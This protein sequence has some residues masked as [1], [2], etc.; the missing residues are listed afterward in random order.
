MSHIRLAVVCLIA[1]AVSVPFAPLLAASA[2]GIVPASAPHGARVIVTGTGLDA[3]STVVRFA[4]AGGGTATA[5]VIS[6]SPSA[7]EVV[8]PL[9]A[10]S[11]DVH[12]SSEAFDIGTFSFTLLP[13]PPFAKVT[14]LAASDKA[15]DVFKDPSGVA[16]IASTGAVVV[17]DR[18]HHQIKVV[19]PNGQVT[20]LAGS[21]KP[22]LADGVGAQATF[23]E[24]RGIAVD[25]TRKVI[26]I[27]DTGNNV[28]RR[29]TYDG[30]VTTF[31]GSGREEDFKQPVGLAVDAAGNVYIADTGNSRIR[32]ISPEGGVTTVA[33]GGHEGFADGP[34]FQALFKQPEGVALDASGAIFVADT[35][36]NVIRKI[37]N[38]LVSTIAGTGHGGYTDGAGS[39]AEF[40]QPSGISVDD[41]GTVY[42]ADV[43]NNVIRRITSSGV[44]ST[45][46]GTGKSGLVDGD[47]A[48][49]Q[50]NQ[51]A[52]IAFASALYVADT[53]NDALRVI[54]PVLRAAA[55]YPHAGPIAGANQVRILGTGFLPGVTQVS[56]ASTPATA[57]TFI[58]PT[59]L[60]VTAPA[61]SA[62]TVDV[63]VTTPAASDVLASSYT[64]LPPPTIASITPRKGKTAGGEVTTLLGTDFVDPDT[65]VSLAGVASPLV[66][67]LTPST[68]T[69][70]TPVGSSGP[71]DVMVSTP[72]GTATLPLGFT[73][74]APP[75][76]ASFSP[77]S[78]RAGTSVTLAGTNFDSEVS[79]N[80]VTFA[81]MFATI[82]SATP[83]SMLVTVPNGALSGPL[84]L[85][86]AGGTATTASSFTVVSYASITI[87]PAQIQLNIT[88]SKQLSLTGGLP[89][90]SSVDVTP[91]AVWTSLN[92]A[93]AT[94][95]ARG[96]VQAAGAGATTIRATLAGLFATGPVTVT[97]A[98]TPPPDPSTFAT[99]IDPTAVTA[100][101]D[102]TAFLYTGPN[103]IQRNVVPG[104]ITSQR[105]AVIRGK[106]VD[107]NGVGIA[108]ARV[109]VL[110]QPSLGYAVTRQD[111]IYDLAANG[112]ATWTLLMS[113]DG[114]LSARRQVA[115]P[116]QDYVAAPTVALLP[117]D[118]HVTTID[119]TQATAQTARGS[120]VTDADG[121]RQATL[122]FA[123]STTATMVLPDG[124]ARALTSLSVRA[125][126]YTVGAAGPMAMPADLP[127][128]SGYTYCVE[129]SVDEAV[130]AGATTVQ[131]SKPVAFYVENFLGFAVGSPV[132]TGYYDTV[133]GQWRAVA[134]GRVVKIVSITNGL[135]DID[136]DGDGAAD[137]PPALATLGIT[138]AERAQLATTYSAGA[139]LWRTALDHFTTWD[140]NWPV[141]P[142]EDA[143]NPNQPFPGFDATDENTC[144]MAGSIIQCQNQ[145]LGE[146]VPVVGTPFNLHYSSDRVL[147][148]TAARTLNISVSGIT[149]PASLRRIDV[150]VGIAG[151]LTELHFPPLPNQSYK[152]VWDGKDAYGRVL[153]GRQPFSLSIG[154]AYPLVYG[155]PQETQFGFARYGNAL[156]NIP[157]RREAILWQQQSG[158]L[159]A[160][161]AAGLGG[162]TIDVAHLFDRR[163]GVFYYGDGTT[164]SA[165][166]AGLTVKTIVTGIFTGQSYFMQPSVAPDGS[167]YYTDFVNRRILKRTLSGALTVVAGG[168]SQPASVDGVPATSASISSGATTTVAPDGTLYIADFGNNRVRKVDG[169][170]LIRTV[171]GNGSFGFLNDVPALQAKV[172]RPTSIAVGKDG[173]LYIADD[174]H[175]RMVGADGFIHTFAGTGNQ[176]TQQVD[177]DGLLA[178]ELNLSSPQVA[179]GPDGYVYIL[180]NVWI[181]RVGPDGRTYR[182]VGGVNPFTGGPTGG[183]NGDGGPARDAFINAPTSLQ[184][185]PDG[186]LFF[187]A[188]GRVR[189]VTPDGIITSIAGVPTRPDGSV[190]PKWSKSDGN[191]ASATN[192]DLGGFGIALSPTGDLYVADRGFYAGLSTTTG[193]I[194]A[195]QL[196]FGGLSNFTTTYPSP[197]GAEV[198]DFDAAGRHTRTRDAVTNATLYTFTYDANGLIASVKD[199]DDLVTTIERDGAGNASAIVAPGG[200]RTALTIGTDGYLALVTDPVGSTSTFAY[201]AGG[202][203]ATFADPRH[204]THTF[205]FDLDGRLIKDAD[206]ASGST[207][208][209]RTI[210]SEADSVTATDG[211]N[212]S[213]TYAHTTDGVGYNDLVTNE[214][215]LVTTV[216]NTPDGNSV[217]TSP[218]GTT[219]TE[220]LSSDPRFGF[221]APLV[222]SATTTLPSQ[223]TMVIQRSRLVSPAG[224]TDPQNFS[225]F[226]ETTS[227][228]GK[229]WTEQYTSATRTRLQTSPTGRRRI[230][231]L[232][233]S[234]RLLS[235]QTGAL[236]PISFMYDNAGRLAV[237]QQGARI[238][239]LTYD[240]TNALTS[241]TDSLDHTIRFTHD[242]AG[243]LVTGTLADS[244]TITVGYDAS[245]N[246]T[247]V[248]PPARLAHTFQFNTIDQIA[249]YV[250][251]GS[252][253]KTFEYNN[254]HDVASISEPDASKL[255]VGYD[256]QG[257]P[258]SV[259]TR[260]GVMTLA[261]DASSGL[262]TGLTNSSE[263]LSMTYDGRLLTDTS[264]NG[265]VVGT[266]N[267]S[268]DNDFELSGETVCGAGCSTIAFGRDADGL[269][270][271]VGALSLTRDQQNGYVNSATAGGIAEQWSYNEFGE[272]AAFVASYGGTDIFSA[273][274]TRDLIGRITES[275][276][277]AGGT[278]VNTTY[279]Y[280]DTG[281]LKTVVRNGTSTSY[282]YD[283]NNNRL[284]QTSNDVSATG[285]YDGQDRVL[286]YGGATYSFTANGDLLTKSTA[287]GTN[288]YAY[289]ALGSLLEV[290]LA[291]GRTIS[292]TS[293]PAG[294][295]ITVKLNGVITH[296]W[297]Y[298]DNHRIAA[299]LDAAGN[300]VS[301]FVYGVRPNAPEL[302]IRGGDTYRLVTDTRGSIRLVVSINTGTIE[303]RI[304]YD[305]FGRVLFDSNPGF[306][307][308]GF[309]GGIYDPQTGL[310]RFGRRDYDPET[311]RWTSRDPRL[312]RGQDTNLYAYVWND[313]INFI[314]PEGLSGM[315]TVHSNGKN[316][317]SDSPI[318]GHSWISYKPDGGSV[319]TYGTYGNHPGGNDNGLQTNWERDNAGK[320]GSLGDSSRSTWLNDQQER[321]L[322]REIEHY[323]RL[324][325]RA[326]TRD[327]PC[328]SFAHDAWLAATGEN[329]DDYNHG[330]GILEQ[331]LPEALRQSIIRENGGIAH[332]VTSFG[333]IRKP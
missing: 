122:V 3:A 297:L 319:T 131:F 64:Y 7:I 331:S 37:Q 162:W 11:G 84:S 12:V 36:N 173:T 51:P 95:D 298:A 288:T 277:Q 309:A 14:T 61:G 307:P 272:A 69:A 27:A 141:G 45:L 149:V 300:V 33:G 268:F 248:T 287:A 311:G 278:F 163:T 66:L 49:A 243:R 244:R 326:W 306:Q 91:Q 284:S 188:N 215:G 110:G 242:A 240:S 194:R 136:A 142:P 123:P 255:S 157:A 317:S 321:R 296:R 324:H 83:T 166:T 238:W 301:H 289:D 209:I 88:Q 111:G 138:D 185:A 184:I 94:V 85:T 192:M 275:T 79:G 285:T 54:A 237:A 62:G 239:R 208:L 222:S 145:T 30:T 274:Y 182:V 257:R 234:G 81:G 102:A 197:D 236:S 31:A 134:N 150:L 216:A 281:R 60:L 328:S 198:Y 164:H 333:P 212:R 107:Q 187:V 112:G 250:S 246:L 206:P 16:V 80:R 34:A 325:E 286:Q 235:S 280:D 89:D 249:A 203:L 29:I 308:F 177:G 17:A 147:G 82:G 273:S 19:A 223:L 146:E 266:V 191:P 90:G 2:T 47:P 172:D 21:G 15:H 254:T 232:D 213:R 152:F 320:Y 148:R 76:I 161:D 86:T 189:R 52:G 259:T 179:V 263:R 230:S 318:E 108:G 293:D 247:N 181:L 10:V 140:C 28:I 219:V 261:Y 174:T 292:Y 26:Y 282:A 41:A 180:T 35:M 8:V 315:L 299:E 200:Q 253:A 196:P 42:A 92:P 265:T 9:N 109:A 169:N 233:A 165:Q 130:A 332:R 116:W 119:L 291:D 264:W 39:L 103:A 204:N 262:L 55:V 256:A 56:F 195:I 176:F 100:F 153:Q 40:K 158:F 201:T 270:T 115:V 186:T 98:D 303:Q 258:A 135:A 32:V 323:R 218:D 154:Y 231:V 6:Q 314:D 226:L 63:T 205:T 1:C 113:R 68:A 245:D 126:E 5:A 271:S 160:Y 132:P 290:A 105:V 167:L 99:T 304:D 269:L 20:I 127:L 4:A 155:G 183:D 217:T 316:G 229:N 171:A 121:T 327:Y 13:D 214:A 283:A 124:T 97:A 210:S 241:V 118:A 168:G 18:S 190:D 74:F 221:A 93:V 23:K 220:T 77:A 207:A 59:E 170:G 65:S 302:M 67:V 211:L 276:E 22:G 114:F 228:N 125:T 129:L 78:G 70:T 312:F 50:F 193:M 48:S 175:V 313:P 227:M 57:V 144:T 151:Q 143:S 202:L 225:V 178:T 25:D 101:A 156:T 137:A 267:H 43:K 279:G 46:A 224:A 58:A 71:A 120:A 295:R 310:V 128:Q 117:V 44:V 106:V 75:T 251:P 73:F 199:Q 330:P 139:S 159:G 260:D 322:M 53:G 329:L 87:T 252:L 96:L 305:E 294:Q 133:A 72:G 24:P 104:A 38:G